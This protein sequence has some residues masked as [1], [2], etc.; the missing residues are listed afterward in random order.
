MAAVGSGMGAGC[1]CS[2]HRDAGEA[3]GAGMGLWDK[4]RARS[5]LFG[6]SGQ[7]EPG[8]GA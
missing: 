3:S 7:V 4:T 6:L 8:C 2:G 5:W 1:C